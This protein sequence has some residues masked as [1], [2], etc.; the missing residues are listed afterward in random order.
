MIGSFDFCDMFKQS[1]DLL[2][3]VVKWLQDGNIK[4][5]RI[6]IS[7]PK[8]AKNFSFLLDFSMQ[9][10]RVKLRHALP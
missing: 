3:V 2:H 7:A 6:F 9:M 8:N 1:L 4:M 10:R 5:S